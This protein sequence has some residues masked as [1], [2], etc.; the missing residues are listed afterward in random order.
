MKKHLLSS[1]TVCLAAVSLLS[2]CISDK[3]ANRLNQKI[4][5]L[6]SQVKT[7]QQTNDTLKSENE[8][9]KEFVKSNCGIELS[10][11]IG[12]SD[13]DNLIK[14]KSNLKDIAVACEMWATDNKG[15]YPKSLSQLTRYY[16]R[17][18]PI[19][20]AAGSDTYSVSYKA[21]ENPDA[22]TM[23]CHGHNHEKVGIPENFPQYNSY[24]GIIER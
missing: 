10:E 14:C 12:I 8:Q 1:L 7:L 13:A 18:V 4:S 23:Y 5:D 3:E 2:G 17:R 24:D 20:P 21:A 9:L 22:H 6:E 11:S 15:H 19:C 16:L